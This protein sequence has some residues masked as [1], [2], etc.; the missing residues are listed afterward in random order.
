MEGQRE[1]KESGKLA[2]WK[3]HDLYYLRVGM[4]DKRVVANLHGVGLRSLLRRNHV[5]S[6]ITGTLGY[7]YYCCCSL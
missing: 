6:R 5:W 7:P 1:D 4:L 3:I 2:A